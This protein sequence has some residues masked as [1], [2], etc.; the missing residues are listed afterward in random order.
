MLLGSH[1]DLYIPIYVYRSEYTIAQKIQM[2]DLVQYFI[3]VDNHTTSFLN[4]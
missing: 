2:T 4:W 3:F 1:V